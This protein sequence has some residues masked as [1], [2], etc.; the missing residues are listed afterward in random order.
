MK[1]TGKPK[2]QQQQQ[3]QR[4]QHEAGSRKRL[5][6]MERNMRYVKCVQEAIDILVRRRKQA[7]SAFNIQW[8]LHLE[9]RVCAEP[10]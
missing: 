8:Y 9:V 6:S 10:C 1:K 4:Q 7:G 3:Q 2:Q 5:E